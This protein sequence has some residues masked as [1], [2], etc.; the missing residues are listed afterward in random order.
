MSENLP[1]IARPTSLT[2]TLDASEFRWLTVRAPDG[3]DRLPTEAEESALRRELTAALQPISPRDLK[4]ALAKMLAAFPQ[5]GPAEPRGYVAVLAEHLAEFPA[6]A[7]DS[8][9]R[10]IVRTSRFLPAVAEVVALAD[11][12]IARRRHAVGALNAVRHE[13]QRRQAKAEAEAKRGADRLAAI[14]AET[15]AKAALAEA[16]DGDPTGWESLPHSSRWTL[17]AAARQGPAALAEAVSA[18]LSFIRRP[19][20]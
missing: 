5:R 17:E 2:P 20:E 7:L 14:A 15:A 8:A 9:C 18:A 13:R 10:Q 11:E 3:Y 1:D 6:D 12:A 16:L 4:T 19:A